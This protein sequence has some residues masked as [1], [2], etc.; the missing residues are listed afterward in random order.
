MITVTME[1]VESLGLRENTLVVF[2]SDHGENYPHRW[3]NHNKRLCYDQ[4]ANV[5][6]IIS[7]PGVLP[8]GKQID[9]VFSTADLAP[10]ILDLC[11]L[12]WPGTL[13]GQSA[14]RLLAG[15]Q[16]GWH[17]DIF[18][19]N[20]P[21]PEKS[22]KKAGADIEMRERC[23]V[24]NRW[25]LILNTSRKPELYDRTSPTP[26]KENLFSRPE[27]KK[28]IADLTECLAA[29]GEKTGDKMTT[30]LIGQWRLG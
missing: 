11:D 28:V 17:K 16:S 27:A 25:K 15:D 29:W 9:N 10:T 2:T 8:K 1:T 6:L 18:I 4:A 7:W 24:T 20:T 5:P 12:P 22:K 3:N 19:Q 14:K 30:Q 13:H 21:Y 26:D 23:V